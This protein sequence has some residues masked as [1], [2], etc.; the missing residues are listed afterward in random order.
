ME[1]KKKEDAEYDQMRKEKKGKKTWLGQMR[2]KGHRKQEVE[3][4][5]SISLLQFFVGFSKIDIS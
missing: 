5:G 4:R 1:D 3:G 2:S